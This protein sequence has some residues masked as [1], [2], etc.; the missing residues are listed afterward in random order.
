M[1][2]AVVNAA[3]GGIYQTGQKRLRASMKE[4]APNLDLLAYDNF[5]AR[6]YDITNRYN[7][8]AACM[9]VAMGMGYDI[10][11]WCDASCV[12]LADPQPLID[13][14]VERGYY[15]ASSGYKASQTCT[16]AQLAAAE[17][18]RD[19]AE[20]IP[21]TATGTVGIHLADAKAN[22]FLREWI[23]W[24]KEGLFAGSR[25]HDFRDSQDPRFMFGRQDQA[26]A[27]LLTYKYGMSLDALGD[28]TAYW[29]GRSRTI[30]AYKGIQ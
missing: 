21:D 27:T 1:K 9:E 10:L 24:S 13:R 8:K 7:V 15:L 17:I 14:I 18:T 11:I 16:D 5:P 2:V 30:I 3:I 23:R 26:A 20:H 6:G 12:F 29:P 4:H 19:E 28:L 25:T 22:T